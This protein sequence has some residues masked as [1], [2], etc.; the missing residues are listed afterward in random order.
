MPIFPIFL[1]LAGRSCLVAGAGAVG[2]G[3]ARSLAEAG[4]EVVLVDP[5][6]AAAAVDLAAGSPR[7][8]LERR[9]FRDDD[10]DGRTLVFACTGD[11]DID[12][13]IERASE[14]AGAICC[15][16]DGRGRASSGALLRRGD[17]C[18]AVSSAGASPALAAEARD[19]IA[20]V[21]GEEFAAA[22][23]LLADLRKNLREQ[24]ADAS[25]RREALAA[26][27]VRALLEDLG[28]G[29]EADARAA[30]DRA[31]EAARRAAC[32]AA[33]AEERRCTR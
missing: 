1:E 4:A 15:R 6:P 14:R 31:L 10:C 13:A 26:P 24:V 27:L 12:T 5:S 32:A 18:V 3:K 16:A 2:A 20:A 25:A 21:V 29:R 8:R 7:V 22:A 28:A 9:E 17:V 33:G 19:R 11:E 30:V 23:G